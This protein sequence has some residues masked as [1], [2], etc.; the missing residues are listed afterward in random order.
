MMR[1]VALDTSTWWGGVALVEGEEGGSETAIRAEAGL[2]VEDSHA[3]HVLRL[4]EVLLREAG[5][6]R[7][8]IDLYAA[9]RGPGSFT[10]IRV[11]LGT[12]RG[13]ALASRRPAIGIGT[14]QA[15]AEA[16]GP[17]TA[18]RVPLLDAG[19]GEV[20]GAR[21]DATSSP[22][23]ELVPPWVGPPERA[24]SGGGGSPVVFGPGARAHRDS[25]A[26]TGS[27]VPPRRGYGSV[28]AAA[29]RIAI[30][31]LRAGAVDGEGLSPLYV[32]PSDAQLKV[33]SGR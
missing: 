15:L 9:T 12:V 5:W 4:L 10:G 28:A 6:D 27:A 19:R 17:A 33:R 11:G 13:L 8:S 21:Y 3:A 26:R 32:R 7:D 31:R 16:F 20:Y 24:V 1:V 25:L 2:L 14:L 23:A 22:P 18:D 29:G 30:L